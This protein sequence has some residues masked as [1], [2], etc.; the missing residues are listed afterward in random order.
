M[1]GVAG[2]WRRALR[3]VR[4]PWSGQV[5][6]GRQARGKRHGHLGLLNLLVAAFAC[7]RKALHRVEDLSEDLGGRVRRALA[8]PRRVSDSTLWRLLARQGVA[9]LR[10]TLQAQVLGLLKRGALEVVALPMGVLSVDGKSLWTSLQKAVEGLASTASGEEGSPRWQLGALRAVLT[11]LVAAPCVDLEFIGGKEG[12]S[13][14]FR[15]LLPRVVAAFGA[16]FGVVTADAGLT[17]RENAALVLSLGKHY[18]FG[19]KGNQPTLHGHAI[20]AIADKRCPPRARTVDRARGE[21][22]VRELWTHALAPGEVDFPGAHLLLLVLQ[23]RHKA[24]GTQVEEWRYFVT[25]LN[26][27]LFGFHQ[28][29]RLVRLH[30]AVENRHNWTLDVVLG[31]DTRQPCLTSRTSLEVV[32][33][34]RALAYNLIA[35]WR[36]ALPR[37]SRRLTTWERACEVL[38]DGLVHGRREVH[39][40]ALA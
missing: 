5:R 8:L 39:Q 19:L 14:A 36:A 4:V 15:Q 32:A 9:G 20:E 34:L 35:T 12:E 2:Q 11:G 6:D 3:H 27:T 16:H 28:L 18:L 38:R 37:R 24:D 22:V 7:G 23:T 21:S 40:P 10:E 31:E 33:W 30:W 26:T 29:L 25:S 17:A 1:S 13:P